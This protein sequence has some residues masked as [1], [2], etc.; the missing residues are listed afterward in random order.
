H[1]STFGGN[2]LACAAA[3]ATVKFILD[4]DIAGNAQKV[5]EYFMA[6]LKK[7]KQKYPFITDVRGLGLLQAMEFSTNISQA[8]LLACL[9]GGLL[10][11]Q[12]KPNALRFIPP[13]IISNKDVDEALDILDK[14]LATMA[15]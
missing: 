7:L 4:N 12:L 13:L 14:A 11:N 8:V 6:R 1:G 15:H 2:P 3:Y 5:G 9:E 10:V